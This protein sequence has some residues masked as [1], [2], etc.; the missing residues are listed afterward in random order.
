DAGRHAQHRIGR[1]AVGKSDARAKSLLVGIECVLARIEEFEIAV[2]AGNGFLDIEAKVADLPKL[3]S[4]RGG[5]FPAQSEI[6]RQLAGELIVILKI[7]AVV[8]AVNLEGR[9]ETEVAGNRS[10]QQHA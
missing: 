3:F 5:I 6:E 10:A 7:Q 4:P 2:V 9:T 1:G 8:A